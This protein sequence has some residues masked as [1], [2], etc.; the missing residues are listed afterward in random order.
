MNRDAPTVRERRGH[1]G[2]LTSRP[3]RQLQHRNL[4]RDF[5]SLILSGF[6]VPERL[7]ALEK[8]SQK[9]DGDRRWRAAR[10]RAVAAATC[11]HPVP[12]ASSVSSSTA[13]HASNGDEAARR[14]RTGALAQ[15][16]AS[17]NPTTLP[18]Q[19][20]QSVRMLRHGAVISAGGG[21][22]ICADFAIGYSSSCGRPFG[23]KV[24]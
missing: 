24:S 6:H 2:L 22:C 1:R 23:A 21:A 8:R 10:P 5:T 17:C 12:P 14:R 18:T 11:S 4:R 15:S 20:A 19:T 9:R 16:S 13:V 7:F 3:A